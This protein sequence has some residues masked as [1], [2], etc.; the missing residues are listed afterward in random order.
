MTRFTLAVLWAI[1]CAVACGGSNPPANDAPAPMPRLCA[2]ALPGVIGVAPLKND[3]S[4]QLDLGGSDDLIMSSMTQSGCFTVAERERL[5]L[6][7]DELRLC[8]DQNAD[9]EYFDCESFPKKGKLVGVTTLVVGSLTFFE[10]NVKGADL[11]LKIPGLGGIEA[12]RSYS[13]LRL[14][15]R[16]V[17]VETAKVTA[18]VDAHALA[19]AD[20]AGVDVSAGG[21]TLRAAAHSKTPFGDSVRS[22]LQDA[23]VKLKSELD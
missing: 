22:M 3:T 20:S 17:D 23:V 16:T 11:A 12:G 1:A 14:T 2:S 7:I 21:F 8:S 15:L 18:S 13:A 5:A 19:P 9:K 6:L 4:A 10:P